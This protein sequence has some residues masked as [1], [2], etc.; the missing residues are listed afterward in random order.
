VSSYWLVMPAAGSGRRFGGPKQHAPLV[1]RT[2][3]ET[4]LQLFI[5]DD[6]CQGGSIVHAPADPNTT[7]LRARLPTRFALVAGGAERA[8]SVYHGLLA[9]ESRAQAQDWVLVHDAAR[10][11]LSAADRDRLLERGANDAVGALLALPVAD[12]VKR[13]HPSA[14]RVEATVARD[15]LWLAQTP[16]MFR[17]APLRAALERAAEA[18]RVPTDEAQAMEWMGLS[19]QLVP[20]TDS[21]FKVTSASD[22]MLAAAILRAREEGACE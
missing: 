8:R 22:L 13:A 19:A 15:R 3:L 17:Y 11:C 20:A 16:Q 5:D 14:A 1:G 21:N 10:P 9:L 6:R 18:A 7:Q 12:T 2:V 4:A